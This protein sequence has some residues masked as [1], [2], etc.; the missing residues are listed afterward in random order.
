MEAHLTAHFYCRVCGC[1]ASFVTNS[2]ID[3]HMTHKGKG[4]ASTR[5]S[6][7]HYQYPKKHKVSLRNWDLFKQRTGIPMPDTP[8]TPKFDIEQR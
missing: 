6:N 3:A 7:Y 1:E 8:P 2:Q 5:R 4:E